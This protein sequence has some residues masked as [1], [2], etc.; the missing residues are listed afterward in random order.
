MKLPFFSINIQCPFSKY[1]EYY[2]VSEK[3]PLT[4]LEEKYNIVVKY[5]DKEI[6]RILKLFKRQRDDPPLPRHMPPIAGR[7]TWANSLK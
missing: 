5:C 7:L 2:K 4:K 1:F 6:D 3:I